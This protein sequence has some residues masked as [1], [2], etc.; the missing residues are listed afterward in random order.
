MKQ[1]IGLPTPQSN[2]QIMFEQ[3]ASLENQFKTAMM[4]SEKIAIAI[5]K[6]PSEYQG[7]LTLEM[8]KEGHSI[9]PSTLKMWPFDIGEQYWVICK[10]SIIDNKSED[11]TDEKE[12]ALMVFNRTCY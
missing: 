12:V 10:N 5:E 1:K 8:R 3:V 4:S 6:L 11:E 7:V 2:P 9:M